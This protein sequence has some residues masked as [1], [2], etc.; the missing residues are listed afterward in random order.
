MKHAQIMALLKDYYATKLE[1]V[2]S[3]IDTEGQL[4]KQHIKSI[5]QILSDQEDLIDAGCDDIAELCGSEWEDPDYNPVKEDLQK[6]MEHHGQFFAED[7]KEYAMMKDARKHVRKNYFTDMLAYNAQVMNFS[8]LDTAG[9]QNK[10]ALTIKPEHR[11]DNIIEKY[12]NEIKSGLKPKSYD[13]QYECLQYL[14]QWLGSEYQITLVDYAKA[15]EAKELLMAT[16]THRNKKPSTKGRSILEQVEIAKLQKLPTLSNT[17][18][19][20]YLGY[21]SGLFAWAKQNHYIEVN[22]FEGIKV[23]GE[24]KKNNRR[25]K[26]EKSEIAKILENLEDT[27]LTKNKSNYWAALIAVYTGARRNEIAALLPDDVKQDPDTGIWYFDITDDQKAGKELKSDA[28]KRIV[29]VHSHL[30]EK[31]F[32]DFVEESRKMKSKIKHPKGLEPRL[33]YDLTYTKQE[34]WG[35][36]LG[37]WFNDKYL[38]AIGLKAKKKSLHSLRHSFITF[39][40]AAGVEGASIK[41]MVGHEPD[42]VTSAIYTHYGIEHLPEFKK[43]LEKLPY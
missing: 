43:A 2:K 42:T 41:S 5:E 1:E 16:P 10:K 4:T 9:K 32:L 12:T 25:Q 20:K 36:K 23:K 18:I 34:K 11:L 31:G 38:P 30:L 13:E 27:D 19:N 24:K 39:L 14:I 7:S 29:P 6:I 21:F 22:P 35:R 3:R 26:I 28:A 17:S 37:H 15:R 33:L 8:L 40:S